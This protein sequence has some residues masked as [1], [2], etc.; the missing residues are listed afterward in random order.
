MRRPGHPCAATFVL[1][2]PL[3]FFFLRLLRLTFTCHSLWLLEHGGYEIG[4]LGR[5][6]IV[7][8]YLLLL[9]GHSL[10]LIFS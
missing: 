8:W 1:G 9:N 10:S 4:G 7:T 5:A 2:T 6:A 3:S